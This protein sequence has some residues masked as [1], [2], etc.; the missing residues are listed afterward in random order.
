M[1]AYR[2]N[3]LTAHV[4]GIVEQ[5]D[6]VAK[7][8]LL[9]IRDGC[10]HTKRCVLHGP[11]VDT[12][13]VGRNAP[14]ARKATVTALGRLSARLVKLNG[15]ITP[16]LLC[17]AGDIEVEVKPPRGVGGSVSVN[18]KGLVQHWD[19]DTRVITTY[20]NGG[21]G[22]TKRVTCSTYMSP[23][24]KSQEDEVVDKTCQYLAVGREFVVNATVDIHHYP[25]KNQNPNRPNELVPC[26]RLVPRNFRLQA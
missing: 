6:P 13:L 22:E 20:L 14:V 16:E 24:L 9:L 11:L 12:L 23:W 26:L 19:P 7:T 21:V 10:A 3:V 4:Y 18:L 2:K 15:N 5:V 25:A 17:R 8:I 1:S